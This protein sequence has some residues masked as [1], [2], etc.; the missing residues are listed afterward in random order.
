ML[1]NLSLKPKYIFKV[2]TSI[3][4]IV[5]SLI[6]KICYFRKKVGL[7][8][9]YTESFFFRGRSVDIMSN[10]VNEF[11]LGRLNR[12]AHDNYI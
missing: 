8:V 5:F 1:G 2:M 9:K 4:N 6:L 12:L 10:D 7:E 3:S 11:A